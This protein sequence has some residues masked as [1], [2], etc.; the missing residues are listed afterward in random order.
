MGFEVVDIQATPNPNAAKFI[1]DKPVSESSTSFFNVEAAKDHPLARNLFAIEGVTSL[2]LLGSF[3]TVN[4]APAANWKQITAKVK[5]VLK[6][7]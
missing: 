1:L 5:K 4:K 6:E 3:V 7:G 2:L